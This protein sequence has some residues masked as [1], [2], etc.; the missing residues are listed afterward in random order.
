MYPSLILIIVN[1][2]HSSVE[3]FGFS[4]TFE[5]R[6]GQGHTNAEHRPATIGNLMF[7]DPPTST[8]DNDESLCL[9]IPLLV[10]FLNLL[11]NQKVT[12]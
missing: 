11:Q 7:A 6:N 3:T 2:G 8:V 10:V 5:S 12:Y 9:D 4:M 1:E